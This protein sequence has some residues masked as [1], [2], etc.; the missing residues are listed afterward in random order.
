MAHKHEISD[1]LGQRHSYF[2]VGVSISVARIDRERS[3]NRACDVRIELDLNLALP[4]GLMVVGH[5]V[6]KL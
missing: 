5:L 1:T 3:C 2:A 6:M 4:C